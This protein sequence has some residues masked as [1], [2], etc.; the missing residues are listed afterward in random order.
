MISKLAEELKKIPEIN[1]PEWSRFVKT[2]RAK[3]RPPEKQDWWHQRS[4]S[5]LYKVYRLGTIGV[6]K[7][8]VKYGSK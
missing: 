8:R 4:A 2:G 5:V 1:P 7:L 3:D 6:Q